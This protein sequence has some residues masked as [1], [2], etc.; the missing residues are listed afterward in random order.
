M[1]NTKIYVCFWTICLIS[2]NSINIAEATSQHIYTD[3]RLRVHVHSVGT[4]IGR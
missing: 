2:V 4:V 1:D 3:K